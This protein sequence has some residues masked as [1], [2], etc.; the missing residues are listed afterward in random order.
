MIGEP[1]GARK[2]HRLVIEAN[3]DDA[4]PQVIGWWTGCSKPARSMPS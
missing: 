2:H 4:S 3:I 1:S